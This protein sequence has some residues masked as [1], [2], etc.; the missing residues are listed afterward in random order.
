M[1]K[2]CQKMF[3]YGW[4]LFMVHRQLCIHLLTFRQSQ[5]KN[6][7]FKFNSDSQKR[8]E[9]LKEQISNLPILDIADFLVNPLFE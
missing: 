8:F 1:Y 5:K 6:V 9:L 2:I 7:K 3:G 4:F